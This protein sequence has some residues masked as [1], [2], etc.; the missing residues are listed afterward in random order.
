MSVPTL[1]AARLPLADIAAPTAPSDWSH[2]YAWLLVAI[3]LVSAGILLLAGRRSDR[4]GHWLGVAAS[5]AAFVLGAAILVSL[6]QAPAA[7]RVVETDLFTWV[8]AG[9]LSLAAGLRLDPLSLTFVL[10][11]TFVGS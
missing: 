4:W 5:A 10:L 7:E 6:L 11:V 3:P 8:S 9:Q 1:I 2:E